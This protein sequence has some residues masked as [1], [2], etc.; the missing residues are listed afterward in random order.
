MGATAHLERMVDWRVMQYTGLK[1]KNG[2]DIYE[3]DVCEIEG[4]GEKTSVGEIVFEYGCFCFKP[5]GARL[6]ALHPELKYY[7]DMEFCE[8]EV[9]GNIY[10]NP[11][12]LNE[13]V[14]NTNKLD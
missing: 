6:G 10:E 14:S 13:P 9:I 3:G 7:V 2:T 11:D 12:L 8:I 1:D 4:G 5:N